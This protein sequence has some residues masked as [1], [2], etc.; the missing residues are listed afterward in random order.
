MTAPPELNS[1]PTSLTAKAITS[2]GPFL[3]P[4]ETGSSLSSLGS[5]PVSMI[6]TSPQIV[7]QMLRM[8]PAI[9]RGI[10]M[11]V[12][13]ADG[14]PRKSDFV[15]F[16]P[17][18]EDE[19][20]DGGSL[21]IQKSSLP[22]RMRSG[23]D[24]EDARS[25]P[26]RQ[27]F[28]AVVHRKVRETPTSAAP[29]GKLQPLPQTPQPQ[30]VKRAT[31]LEAPLSPGHGELAALLHEAVLL[32]NTLNKGEL[33]SEETEEETQ[34]DDKKA[35]EAAATVQAKDDKAEDEERSRMALTAAQ[36]QS[37]RDDPTTG[38]LKHTFLVP[39]S[40]VRSRHRKEVYTAKAESLLSKTQEPQSVQPESANLPSQSAT[41]SSPIASPTLPKLSARQSI[42]DSVSTSNSI[43]QLPPKFSS[44]RNFGSI[45]RATAGGGASTRTSH[46]RS[47]EISSEESSSAV[48]LDEFGLGGTG[49]T[50]SFPSVS[51]KKTLN[52]L[53][54]ATSFAEKLWSRGRTK[55]G[56]STLSSTTE[57]KGGISYSSF[58][59]QSLITYGQ[60]T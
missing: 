20:S 10:P 59:C 46:S 39:L 24:P 57:V 3:S 6:E 56:G 55:S 41:N 47:S 38:R 50:L 30:R 35:K 12:P 27:T 34:Q 29:N 60:N 14:H 22:G 28:S 49:S 2:P 36:L 21:T 40:K 25:Q 7:T 5:R 58:I 13:A 33:P 51:P 53:A 26:S 48:A 11:F 8:T 23:S 52:P 42:A 4:P 15:H 18:P 9:S 16:P 32:E 37:K 31:I 17:T 54:R 44:L 43:T 19:T 1:L 45:S